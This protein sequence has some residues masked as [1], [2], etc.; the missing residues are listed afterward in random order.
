MGS[1]YN[2][3]FCLEH[4]NETSIDVEQQ[5]QKIQSFF[6]TQRNHFYQLITTQRSLIQHA[7]AEPSLWWFNNNFSTDRYQSLVQQEIDIFLILHNID[8]AVSNTRQISPLGIWFYL[9]NAC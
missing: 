9:V 8:T 3:L 7:S 1:I 6:N 5:E 2:Q 4:T